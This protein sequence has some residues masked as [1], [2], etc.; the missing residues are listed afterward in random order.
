[1]RLN[2][3]TTPQIARICIWV[4]LAL[5]IVLCLVGL[6]IQEPFF[7]VAPLLLLYII[8]HDFLPLPA[9]IPLVAILLW[10]G[11]LVLKVAIIVRE[12]ITVYKFIIYLSQRWVTCAGREFGAGSSSV[13]DESKR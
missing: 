5:S 9:F 13:S 2:D 1:M 6:V 11:P 3:W 8:D 7:I 10:A 4:L 12:C